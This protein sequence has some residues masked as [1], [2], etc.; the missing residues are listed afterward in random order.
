MSESLCNALQK[1]GGVRT[2]VR[3]PSFLK[4]CG[5]FKTLDSTKCKIIHCMVVAVELASHWVYIQCAVVQGST[6]SLVIGLGGSDNMVSKRLAPLVWFTKNGNKHICLCGL[7]DAPAIPLIDRKRM[8]ALAAVGL[9][10]GSFLEVDCN[11][12]TKQALSLQC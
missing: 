3:P 12:K 1:I 8:T 5:Q 4:A 11:S 2:D 9:N 10:I 7:P 6:C